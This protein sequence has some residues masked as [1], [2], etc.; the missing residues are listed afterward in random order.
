MGL[1]QIM[2]ESW[3]FSASVVNVF[4][5]PGTSLLL[6]SLWDSVGTAARLSSAEVA[7]K[8]YLLPE[9]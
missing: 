7:V 9:L 4:G 3:E 8:N 1:S 5:R 2:K 6:C